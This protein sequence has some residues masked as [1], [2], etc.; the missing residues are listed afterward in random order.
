MVLTDQQLSQQ[1]R[2][3]LRD[4]NISGWPS[5][6]QP[7]GNTLLFYLAVLGEISVQRHSSTRERV[8]I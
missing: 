7:P 5:V 4:G 6:E 1:S 2:K 3:L 8:I